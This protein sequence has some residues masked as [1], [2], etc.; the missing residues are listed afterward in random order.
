MREDGGAVFEARGGVY[1]LA[2]VRL[3]EAQLTGHSVDATG[4]AEL[5]FAKAELAVLFA[6]L[7][8][9]L[10]LR[11][12]AV[13]GLDGMEVLETVYHDER[14]EHGAG[15]GEDTHL[16]RADGIGGFNETGIVEAMREE[17]FRRADSATTHGLLR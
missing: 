10:L 1:D 16:A 2:R 6:E 4:A 9:N 3:G 14:K 17:D 7:V 15:G 8:E 12:D 11:L 13:G 5:S